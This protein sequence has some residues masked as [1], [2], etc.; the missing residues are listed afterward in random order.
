MPIILLGLLVIAGLLIFMY[1]NGE[2]GSFSSKKS[3]KEDAPGDDPHRGKVITLPNDMEGEKK[4]R[5]VRTGK[6]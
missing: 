1:H 3:K 6:D 4:K 5:H 2:L